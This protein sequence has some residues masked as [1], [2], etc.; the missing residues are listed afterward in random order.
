MWISASAIQSHRAQLR[1]GR[2]D[3]LS[4]MWFPDTALYPGSAYRP[5]QETGHLCQGGGLLLQSIRTKA[6]QDSPGDSHGGWAYIP[7]DGRCVAR[8]AQSYWIHLDHFLHRCVAITAALC[9]S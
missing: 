1:M 3:R 5:W 6:L 8:A 4:Q 7:Q 9:L 2:V